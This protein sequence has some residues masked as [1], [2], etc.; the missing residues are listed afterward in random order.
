MTKKQKKQLITFGM[1]VAAGFILAKA[2]APK[3]TDE[4]R[5]NGYFPSKLPN[6]QPQWPYEVVWGAAKRKNDTLHMAEMTV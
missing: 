4:N 6:A 2:L 5:V 3:N 1:G